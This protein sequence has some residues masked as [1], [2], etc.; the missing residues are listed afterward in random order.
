MRGLVLLLAFFTGADVLAKEGDVEKRVDNAIEK[1][2]VLEVSQKKAR[3]ALAKIEHK[4]AEAAY[5]QVKLQHDALFRGLRLK[6]GVTADDYR[7]S[8]L[9]RQKHQ[10]TVQIKSGEVELA[11]VEL[12]LAELRLKMHRGK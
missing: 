1:A 6:P 7:L 2:L 9:T 4:L 12:V 8:V 3:L 5:E 10:W 11:R